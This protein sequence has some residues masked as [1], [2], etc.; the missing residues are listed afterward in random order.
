[1]AKK[2]SVYRTT[3]DIESKRDVGII[4]VRN[5]EGERLTYEGRNF[6]FFSY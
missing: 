3:S 5:A 1:M 6:H 2:F 4:Q